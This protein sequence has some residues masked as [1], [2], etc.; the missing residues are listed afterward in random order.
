MRDTP[1][2]RR[3]QERPKKG[4]PFLRMGYASPRSRGAAPGGTAVAPRPVRPPSTAATEQPR[5]PRPRAA[6]AMLDEPTPNAPL[7]LEPALEDAQRLL[8]ESLTEI[9]HTDPTAADT[10]EMIRLDEMLAI[11]EDAAKRAVSLRR[12]M[13]QEGRGAPR[14]GSTGARTERRRATGPE[15]GMAGA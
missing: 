11:A 4:S 5:P 12:R 3:R 7:P 10:G 1:K 6:T 14:S 2:S 8:R 9:C 13:R 15:A